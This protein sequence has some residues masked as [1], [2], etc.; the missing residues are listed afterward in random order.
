MH[1]GEFV[2]ITGKLMPQCLFEG[3]SCS[4]ELKWTSLPVT[5]SPVIAHGRILL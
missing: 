3:G 4:K 5:L 1:K 2:I